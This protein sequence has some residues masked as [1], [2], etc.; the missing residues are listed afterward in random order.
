MKV[1]FQAIQTTVTLITPKATAGVTY[2][3]DKLATIWF[4]STPDYDCIMTTASPA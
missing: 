3:T 1:Q 2:I 4:Y